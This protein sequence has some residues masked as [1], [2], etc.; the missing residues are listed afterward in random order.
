MFLLFQVTK[1]LNLK[2]K[3]CLITGANSGIGL[4]I[5]RCLSSRDCTLLMAC[6]NTYAANVVAKNICENTDR[7]RFYEINLASLR[8]VKKCCDNILN[9]EK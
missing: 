2:N 4:E 1:G 8:S 9:F 3:T 7:L 5:T 6:R